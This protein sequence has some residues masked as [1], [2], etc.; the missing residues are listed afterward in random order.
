MKPKCIIQPIY[1]RRQPVDARI[2]AIEGRQYV[3][4][5]TFYQNTET[6]QEFYAIAGSIAFPAGPNPGFGLVIG[7]IKEPKHEKAPC[8]QV[9]AE[10]EEQDLVSLLTSCEQIRYRWGYPHQLK[11]FIG[12][13]GMY[14][15]AIADFNDLIDT[16]PEI[17]EGIY[18]SHPSDFEYARRDAL[19]L[20]TVTQLLSATADGNKR[21]LI[22]D[23]R[24][25]RT[26]L[27]NI[28]PDIRKVEDIPALAALSYACHTLLATSPWLVFTEP[29]R[30]V[31][32]I[33]EDGYAQT[34][35]WPWEYDEPFQWDDD[36]YFDDGI[37]TGTVE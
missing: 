18:L 23:N 35:L 30:F 3:R 5:P 13:A 28:P 19:Y 26:H 31:P 8:L 4:K 1:D 20:Q 33:Q 6:G 14:L 36:E 21:L 2:A 24:H 25:L 27:Q 15:Q 12:D 11:F 37:L 34:S 29:Q 10:I 22:G 9:L 32:T 7:A 16:K 17:R